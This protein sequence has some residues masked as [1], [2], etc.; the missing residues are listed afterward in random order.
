MSAS[1]V[2]AFLAGAVLVQLLGHGVDF[3]SAARRER[4]AAVG[5]L[6]ELIVA[7][8]ARGLDSHSAQREAR[9]WARA[10]AVI[11]AYLQR[12]GQSMAMPPEGRRHAP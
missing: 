12:R 10:R 7:M 1:V 2:I 6:R 11:A 8:H 5:A 3:G 9:A 4:D